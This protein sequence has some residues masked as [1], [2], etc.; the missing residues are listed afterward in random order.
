MS[1]RHDLPPDQEITPN[2]PEKRRGRL[3]KAIARTAP[4]LAHALGGPLAGA[5]VE[6]I[7]RAILGSPGGDEAILAE[8][9]LS[10]R[11]DRGAAQG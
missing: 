3:K 11:T 7:S 5:A 2:P 10:A 9:G 1:E 4:R 8:A 6:A